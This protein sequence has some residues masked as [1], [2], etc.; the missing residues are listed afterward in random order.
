MF[1]LFELLNRRR[2]PLLIPNWGNLQ[3]CPKCMLTFKIF[4]FETFLT[5]PESRIVG[6]NLERVSFSCDAV[7]P[8]FCVHD[9]V[10]LVVYAGGVAGMVSVLS[11]VFSCA[12]LSS[13]K[14]KTTAI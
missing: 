13:N 10:T 9:V 14:I 8:G 6:L 12:S 4:I 5:V 3:I 1:S 2:R 7:R 11:T